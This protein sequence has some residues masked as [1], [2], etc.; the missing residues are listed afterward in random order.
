MSSLVVFSNDLRISDNPSLTQALKGDGKTYLCFIYDKE[1]FHSSHGRANL[2]WLRKSLNELS[3][4]IKDLG[5]TLNIISGTFDKKLIEI[6][7]KYHINNVYYN[8]NRDPLF[9]K[10]FH[11]FES[12]VANHVNVHRFD[13][14]IVHN[15]DNC[16]N[17]S[18][19][20]FKVY[21]PFFKYCKLQY[22]NDIPLSAPKKLATEPLNEK[23]LDLSL[24][25]SESEKYWGDKFEKNWEV[26]EE[27]AQ[28][29][30]KNFVEYKI[31]EYK[32]E[33]DFPAKPS[34]SMLSPHLRFG[35]I[36]PRQIL[37]YIGFSASE[38]L[39]KGSE[40]FAKEIYWREFSHYILHHFPFVSKKPFNKKFENFPWKNDYRNE[41]HRW[42]YGNTGIKLIDAAMIQLWHTGWMH[43]RMRML[44][45]SYLT[46]NLLIHWLEG[47]KWFKDTL[48][49][50]DFANNVCGWQWVAGTGTDAAPY[51][52]IFNPE[53]QSTKFDENDEYTTKWLNIRG[54]EYPSLP[55][56]EGLLVDLSDSRKRA[57]EVF[58]NI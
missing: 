33:R 11:E 2:W 47:E 39:D 41:L 24:P 13:C 26:G 50:A 16:F 54:K 10:A 18:G 5:G 29:K 27:A 37:H 44:V 28:N 35:E 46:K 45:A 25:F 58:S 38:E 4:K 32:V 21:T 14:S 9:K 1:L 42:K 34:T 3:I 7:N 31:K 48:V 17:K 19:E 23:S 43:N 40:H 30:L 56:E 8:L 22:T 57:L 12:K 20:P 55:N 15:P 51:F 6:T 52:R 36:S 49:D 53:V